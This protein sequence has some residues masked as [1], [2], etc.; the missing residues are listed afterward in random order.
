M[1]FVTIHYKLKQTSKDSLNLAA[2][3]A[4]ID[5]IMDAVMKL[6]AGVASDNVAQVQFVAFDLGRL[7]RVAPVE[8]DLTSLVMRITQLSF[9]LLGMLVSQKV[10]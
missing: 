9:R 5:D 8:T 6:D 7:P 3:E 4:E 2:H 1:L 10:M